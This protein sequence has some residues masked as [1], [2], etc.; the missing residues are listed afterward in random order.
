M[1]VGR[2]G[3][4]EEESRSFLPSVRSGRC[5]YSY[6]P[7]RWAFSTLMLPSFC[8]SLSPVTIPT[9]LEEEEARSPSVS[10]RLER[11]TSDWEGTHVCPL[12]FSVSIPPS[13]RTFPCD[14]ASFQLPFSALRLP[15][16]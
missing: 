7:R 14:S 3:G 11:E 15:S 9:A 5:F 4:R 2:E 12:A 10:R 13:G 8:L 16:V 6:F 1:A